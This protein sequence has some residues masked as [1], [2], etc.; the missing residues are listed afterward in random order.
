[1]ESSGNALSDIDVG[2]PCAGPPVPDIRKMINLSGKSTADVALE[3]GVPVEQLEAMMEQ[4]DP[5]VRQWAPVLAKC[6]RLARIGLLKLVSRECPCGCSSAGHHIF[7]KL[8]RAG[9]STLSK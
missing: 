7:L 9:E 2:F 1:V 3:M 8:T 5:S 4:Q 6:T